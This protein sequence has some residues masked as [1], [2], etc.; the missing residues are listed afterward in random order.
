MRA[1]VTDPA[2]A[3]N[4][5]HWESCRIRAATVK[6]YLNPT[7]PDAHELGLEITLKRRR[8]NAANRPD[9]AAAAG[10]LACYDLTGRRPG[11]SARRGEANSSH[12]VKR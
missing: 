6:P 12:H 4:G 9:V 5:R 10:R 1:I 8:P 3:A 11:M 7:G 2:L